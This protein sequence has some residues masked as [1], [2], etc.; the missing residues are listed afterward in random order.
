MT[1][2]ESA[3]A[4]KRS[5]MA[6]FQVLRSVQSPFGVIFWWFEQLIARLD[7]EIERLGS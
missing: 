4:K 6:A 1:Q 5:L 7:I 3:P 2:K